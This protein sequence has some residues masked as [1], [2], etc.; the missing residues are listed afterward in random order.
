MSI[1]AIILAG[2][3]G[4]RF[5]PKSRESSPKQCLDIWGGK[6]LIEQTAERIIPTVSESGIIISTNPD[7]EPT[8]RNFLPQAEYIIEPLPKNTA[9]GIGLCALK[10]AAS[11]PETILIILPSDHLIKD[12]ENYRQHISFCVEQ[13]KEGKIA[14]LGITPSRPAT[15]YGYIKLGSKVSD[16]VFKVE[17]FVEKPDKKTAEEYVK[18]KEY[19]WNAGMF[20]SKA[21][22]MLDAIKRHMPKLYEGLEKIRQSNFNDAEATGVFHSLESI[23]IDYGVME[24]E[25]GL[26]VVK[27]DFDWD[28]VGNWAALGRIFPK[29]ESG[30]VVLG[31]FKGVEAKDCIVYGDKLVAAIGVKNLIIVNT[32]DACLVCDKHQAEKVKDIVKQLEEEY[33]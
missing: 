7:M 13:A 23:S 1:K 3:K 24:K 30:N 9:A 28:D 2:G 20:I 27:G 18:S 5:W 17:K 11:D 26:V 33:R 15:G 10:V 22:V 12:A 25:K 6:T 14:I 8:M 29:N 32:P 4:E 31:K 19:L 16:K 21:G